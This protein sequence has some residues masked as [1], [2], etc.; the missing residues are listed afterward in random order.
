MTHLPRS[1]IADDTEVPA[2]AVYRDADAPVDERVADLLA[3]MTLEEKAGQLFQTMV[4]IGDGGTIVEESARSGRPGTSELVVERG[5]THLNALG[6]PETARQFALWHNRLQDLARSTRLGIPVTVS[7][8][9]RHSFSDNIGAGLPAGPF[10]QWPET[11]GLAAIGDAALVEEFADT[12]RRE[13][14]AVG[15]RT[16]LH[17]QVDLLTEP[18]WARGAGTFGEDAALTSRLGAAYVHGLQG[19][20]RIA[21]STAVGAGFGVRSVSAMTKHFPGGGPQKDGEDPHFAYGREQVYP[22]DRFDLHLRPFRDLIAAGTR[23]MMPYYGMPIGLVLDGEPVEEVG[24]GFNRQILTGLLRE[25]L[26]FTGV[27]CTDWGLITDAEAFGAPFPARAWG[28]EHLTPVERVAKVLDAGADQFGGEACPE[29]VVELVRSGRIGEARIDLSVGRLLREK[30]LLGLFDE[31][32]YVDPDDAARTV[33]TAQSRAAGLRA[34]SRALTVLTA[35]DAGAAALPLAPGT[36][37]HLAGAHTGARGPLVVTAEGEPADVTVL[38]LSAPYEERGPGFDALFH[39]GSLDFAPETID[40]VR[41]VA[42]RGPVIVVVHLDRPAVLAP[43][44]EAADAV[45]VDFGAS[46]DAVLAALAGTVPPEG[47]LPFDL[48]RS[49][50]AVEAS[51]EDV[52]FDTADPLFRFGHGLASGR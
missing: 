17:P 4:E 39:A 33:G 12:V 19:T 30:F 7:T 47:R 15:L 52:P 14:L 31:G 2:T 23:Q 37:V 1:P 6:A 22:G 10:S 34:Q 45:L 32:R 24:F 49:M 41:E 3:R 50:A 28:V 26:G 11:L 16:A 5:L 46:D 43:I 8:D 42:S 51:R 27:I 13:Y 18:R 29:H 36:R 44:V 9:P 35:P 40:R 21:A 48:P 25:R 38:R 20:G